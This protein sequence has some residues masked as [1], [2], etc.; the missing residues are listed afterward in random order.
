MDLLRLLR[1]RRKWTGAVPVFV[2]YYPS[3]EDMDSQQFAFFS[4]LAKEIDDGRHPSVEGNISYLFAYVYGL[5]REWKRK[6]FGWVHDR[7]VALAQAYEAEP[8]FALYCREWSYDCLLG[9]KRYDEYL[10]ATEPE[11]IFATDTHSS[12]MRCNVFYVLGCPPTGVDLLNLFGARI[13]AFTRE[14]PA[15]FRD[16]LEAALEDDARRNGPWLDRLL[17]AQG[18]RRTYGSFLLGEAPLPFDYYCFYAAY[19]YAGVVQGI[20]RDAENRLREAHAVPKVGEGWVAETALFHAVRAAFPGISVVQH[21]MPPWLGRQHLDIWI[22]EWKIA[23]EYQGAQHFE[24]VDYFGG[25][26]TFQLT[27]ERDARKQHLCRASDVTL[28]IATT[29]TTHAA[30]IE[31][32]ARACRDRTQA[33]GESSD[34]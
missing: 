2:R 22:P 21:G 28:I 13:T 26:E 9:L 15:A 10:L 11:D 5:L 34:T 4:Y 6:G 1:G 30:V 8:K 27:T 33:G 32:I 31:Q 24:P 17:E 12:N 23:V 16:F 18:E 19:D 29:E 14:H 25:T 20:V 7:L 3:V